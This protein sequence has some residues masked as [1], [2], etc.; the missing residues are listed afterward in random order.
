MECRLPA[1]APHLKLARLPE[2]DGVPKDK[3]TGKGQTR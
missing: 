2:A 3:I 1:E